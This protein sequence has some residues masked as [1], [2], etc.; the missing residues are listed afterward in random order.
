ML[1]YDLSGRGRAPLYE[2]LCRCLRR[3]ILSGA[4]RPGERLPSKRA[5]A[6]HLGVSV[7]TVDAA[8][9]QLIAEGC[10]EARARRGCFVAELPDAPPPEAAAPRVPAAP[11]PAPAWRAD[12]AANH[13]AEELFPSGTWAR[14]T[15]RA[16]SEAPE[17]MLRSAPHAG[18][19]ELREAI[20]GYLR[21]YKGLDVTAERV[22]VGAG[23]EFLYLML[24][25]FFAGAAF[26][27]EDPGYPKIR[28]AYAR[29]GVQCLPV[30][31]DSQGVDAAALRAS[32]A[33]VLHISPAHQYPTGLVTPLS[34][35]R[36]LLAWAR[37]A[38]GYVIEDDYDSELSGPAMPLPTLGSI[39]RAGRVI[40]MN[41][42]SQTISP[43]MRVS[44][45]VLPERLLDA[46]RERLGFY[47]CA[48]PVLEQLVLAR[49]ISSGGY[50]RHLARLRKACREWRV[51][52][53]SAFGTGPLAGRVELLQPGA[54][55]HFLMRVDT[56]LPDAEL[57]A[58]A[59]AL[60][61][62]LAFLSDFAFDASNAPEHVLVVNYAGL[63]GGALADA[64]ELLRR[65][66][67]GEGA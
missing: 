20:A 42:F 30:P 41:T 22:V 66:L 46:W 43:G 65:A 11:P 53:L 63:S 7:V 47:S 49:F 9:A 56:A 19:Y 60:R 23:S 18:L 32:G 14:L 12:L 24:A 33:G 2:Y 31:L 1:T 57:R 27:L 51:R 48:V 5:L 28:L 38:G 58:R 50:E 62:R 44:Y 39:D 36:E 13:V 25:Q 40:Y 54:G 6:E 15:R 3:D 8:Y 4:L 37:D 55:L 61:L 45:L 35:R 64:Q 21:G 67:D 52:S 16:L 29:S 26:A 17:A 10:V 34:R 59:A